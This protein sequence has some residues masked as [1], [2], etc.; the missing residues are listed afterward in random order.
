M[1]EIIADEEILKINEG[2]GKAMSSWI[3]SLLSV[4]PPTLY[5]LRLEKNILFPPKNEHS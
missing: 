4:P 1:K 3:S 2:V 5:L